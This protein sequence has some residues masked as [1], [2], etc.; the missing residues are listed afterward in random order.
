MAVQKM[1]WEGKCGDG[2]EYEAVVMTAVRGRGTIKVKAAE[3]EQNERIQEILR[4]VDLQTHKTQEE[5][6]RGT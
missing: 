1:N 4:N 3:T 5:G 2:T 6:A